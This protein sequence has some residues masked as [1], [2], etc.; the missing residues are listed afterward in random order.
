MKRG[1]LLVAGMVGGAA[2]FM[3]APTPALRTARAPSVLAR[4][5][6]PAYC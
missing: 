1:V 4:G 5:A 6:F 2:A 3:P